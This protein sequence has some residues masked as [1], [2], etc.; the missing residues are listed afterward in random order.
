[1]E[2]V[3]VLKIAEFDLLKDDS[4]TDAILERLQKEYATEEEGVDGRYYEVSIQDHKFRCAYT[5]DEMRGI[6]RT[7]V[8]IIKELTLFILIL[9]SMI[10]Y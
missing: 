1:M 3:K 2:Y 4:Y 6:I 10:N 9:Q 8:K 5:D 7:C